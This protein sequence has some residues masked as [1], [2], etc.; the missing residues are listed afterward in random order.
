MDV[1]FDNVGGPILEALLGLAMHARVVL[2]GA[3]SQYNADD[4][5]AGPR[6]YMNLLINRARMEGVVVFDFAGRHKE[7]TAQMSAWMQQ[8]KLAAHEDIA[9]ASVADFPETL[10]RLFREESSTAHA[11]EDHPDLR[12]LKTTKAMPVARGGRNEQQRQRGQRAGGC[13]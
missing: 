7:G 13:V 12:A 6:N 11:A 4:G 5:L 1:H 8:G 10:L 2:C 3:V 9:G